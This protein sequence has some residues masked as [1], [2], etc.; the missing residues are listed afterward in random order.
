MGRSNNVITKIND[1]CLKNCSDDHV[2][3][4]SFYLNTLTRTM[5]SI[6]LL[7]WKFS[8]EIKNKKS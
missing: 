2:M 1:V 7:D 6:F 4:N 5:L 3:E 8:E